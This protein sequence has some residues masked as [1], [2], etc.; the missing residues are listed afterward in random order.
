MG[1]AKMRRRGI[2][3]RT[4]KQIRMGIATGEVIYNLVVKG[5]RDAAR[6]ALYRAS[7]TPKR[8]YVAT[9][10][11]VEKYISCNPERGVV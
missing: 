9:I 6:L 2:S 5:E 8:T 4:A 3:V 10:R 1:C 7:K 11:T